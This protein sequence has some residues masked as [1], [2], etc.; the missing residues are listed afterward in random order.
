[1]RTLR[2]LP[3]AIAALAA[4]SISIGCGDDDTSEPMNTP[5]AAATVKPT[6]SPSA[7]PDA[8]P[9]STADA[10]EPA[11]TADVGPAPSTDTDAGTEPG[12]DAQADTGSGDDAA[13]PPINCPAVEDRQV[14]LVNTEL[15]DE[16]GNITE[17]THFTCDKVY[18]LTE[19]TFIGGNSTL[20]MDP[21]TVV[22]GFD[23]SALIVTMGSKL[24]AVG[25]KEAPIVLTS[26]YPDEPVSGDWG[27]LVLL[28]E[29]A[30]NFSG[31]TNRIEG[32][33]TDD[34]RGLY[35]GALNP[36]ADW[37]CG[38][39]AYVRVEFAGYELTDGKELNGISIAGCGS[40]TT[41]DYVQVHAGTDDGIEIWGGAPKLRHIV[42]TG[43]QDDSLDWDAG[44]QGSAQFVAIQHHVQGPFSSDSNGFEGDNL[45]NAEDSTPVS[46]PTISNVTIVGA[47]LVDDLPAGDLYGM[48]L[49]RGTAGTIM[50]SIV[51]NFAKGALNVGTSSATLAAAGDLVVSNTL[52]FNNLNG[53]DDQ[54]PDETAANDDEGFIEADFFADG[55]DNVFDQDPE[56][57]DPNNETAPNFIPASGSPASDGAAATPA[58]FEAADYLGAFEPGGEDWTEGWT[59]YPVPN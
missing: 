15:A 10:A 23:G 46:D 26:G 45:N 51:M 11:A 27:G 17:D 16:D 19:L 58:G 52:F 33:A 44:W 59:A 30:V 3:V 47:G 21:G 28:G 39:L 9:V 50:N 24:E 5:D 31:G 4:A 1:M 34:D 7:K 49:R 54:F 40:K 43:N 2:I 36:K 12:A 37:D 56:L 8:G 22:H 55:L 18:E 13:V 38:Q 41:L 57:A 53:G 35:G 29:A 14:V 42:L 25:T 6:A 32:I 20:T 48:T